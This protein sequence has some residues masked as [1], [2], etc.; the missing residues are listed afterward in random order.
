MVKRIVLL[1]L[2]AITLLLTLPPAAPAD[3][4]VGPKND[5]YDSHYDECVFL[6][7]AFYANGQNGFVSVKEEPGATEEIMAIKNGESIL[8]QYAYNR[9]GQYWGATL[10]WDPENS[11]G[12]IPLDD[13]MLIYDYISFDEQHQSEYYPYS[14]TQEIWLT[15]GDIVFWTWP[16]SGRVAWTLEAEYRNPKTDE[17]FL[18]AAYAYQDN[19]GREWGFFQYVYGNKNYWACLSDPANKDIPAFNPPPQPQLWP[20][21]DPQSKT[22]LP[23]IIIAFLSMLVVGATLIVRRS[24]KKIKSK[25]L[26]H[27]S[28]T[29]RRI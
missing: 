2:L 10:L 24:L 18:Q 15:E 27:K 12:W 16:G 21:K 11:D 4:I 25:K 9:N 17:S 1:M 5:F 8:I 23:Q 28:G 26:Q 7:R 22:S 14:G 29:N 19:E 6:G 3:I 13:L 20:A